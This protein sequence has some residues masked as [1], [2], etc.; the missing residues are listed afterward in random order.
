MSDRNV[1]LIGFMGSGKS[2]VGEALADSV[3]YS[4]VDTDKLIEKKTGRKIKDIIPTDGE[5]AF[6]DLET[7]AIR[8][9]ADVKR[10][11]ISVGGG[12]PLREENRKLLSRIGLV[13]H[14]SATPEEIYQRVK[15]ET[16][17]PLLAKSPDLRATI[18]DML[19]KRAE[20]YS[21]ADVVVDTTLLSV[22]E[23]VSK[24][25]EIL[26]RDTRCDV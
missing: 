10:S 13:I 5:E 1:V 6:R 18:K 11:I 15:H 12:A 16:H 19:A 22:E 9:L 2:S 20:A 24:C 21:F 23:V 4:Y 25:I 8:G 3:G 26:A 7:E 17:R 14:L